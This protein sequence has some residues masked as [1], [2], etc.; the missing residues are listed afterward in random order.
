MARA[1]EFTN[2]RV[3]EAETDRMP[4]FVLHELAH[5]YHHRCLPDG[6]AHAGIAEAFA[7]A[8]ASGSYDRVERRFGGGR[9]HA[10]ERAYALTSAQEYFAETTEAFFGRNDFF[11]F[12]REELLRHDPR[13]H[14]LLARL[15]GVE[16]GRG[17]APAD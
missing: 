10:V 14:A 1:V 4:N 7:R 16:D 3:F 12:T 2:V 15:W 8:G 5:A 11:P 6:F 9:P 17:S 13:M